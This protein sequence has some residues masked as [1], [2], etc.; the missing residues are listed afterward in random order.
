MRQHQRLISRELDRD[1][2]IAHAYPYGSAPPA[3]TRTYWP[4]TL[5]EYIGPRD[6]LLPL[7]APLLDA[8]PATTSRATCIL[9]PDR[10]TWSQPRWCR[11]GRRFYTAEAFSRCPLARRAEGGDVDV[12]AEYVDVTLGRARSL[13]PGRVVRTPL[14]C[15]GA[16]P[17]VLVRLVG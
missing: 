3:T 9:G 2:T 10:N 8:D 13:G 4:P 15:S 6:L 7:T 16:A 1:L 11:A 14:E 5:T 17:T 12:D